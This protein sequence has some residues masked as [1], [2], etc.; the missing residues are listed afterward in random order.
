MILFFK[1]PAN[2]IFEN[3]LLI[4]LKQQTL[5]FYARKLFCTVAKSIQQQ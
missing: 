2:D 3:V 4:C 5:Y 1:P